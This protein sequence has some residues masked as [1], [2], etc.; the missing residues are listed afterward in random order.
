MERRNI[1]HAKN[2]GFMRADSSDVVF[3]STPNHLQRYNFKGESKIAFFA[4]LEYSNTSTLRLLS[5]NSQ[6]LSYY[7]KPILNVLGVCQNKNFGAPPR[8]LCRNM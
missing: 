3:F 5:L 8:T 2:W 6:T 4:N 7:A 1:N